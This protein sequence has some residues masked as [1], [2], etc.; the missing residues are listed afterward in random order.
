MSYTLYMMMEGAV[1]VRQG[2]QGDGGEAGEPQ[3][4]GGSPPL[5]QPEAGGG[6]EGVRAGG[7]AA[8]EVL[9]TTREETARDAREVGAV[10][11]KVKSVP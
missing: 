5:G 1:P 11:M 9:E 7:G 8:T 3:C 2:V 10:A 4:G 6:A